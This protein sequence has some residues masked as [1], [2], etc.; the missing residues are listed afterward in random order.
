[1]VAAVG[2]IDI[3]RDLRARIAAAIRERRET[4]SQDIATIL[5]NS[6][7]LDQT[8]WQTFGRVM[9]DL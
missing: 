1:M 5:L 3:P 9:V 8:D 6:P 7:Q 2:F 4:L